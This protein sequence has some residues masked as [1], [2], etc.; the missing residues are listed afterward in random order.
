MEK[1]RLNEWELFNNLNITYMSYILGYVEFIY[2]RQFTISNDSIIASQEVN[3][4]Q[5][6]LKTTLKAKFKN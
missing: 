5:A 1:K 4:Y 6:N 3:L 2:R